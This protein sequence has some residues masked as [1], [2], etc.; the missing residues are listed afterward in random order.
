MKTIIYGAL[1]L[2]TGVIFLLLL[3][4]KVAAQVII[5]EVLPNPD[6]SFAKSEWVELYNMGTNAVDLGNWTL[7]GKVIPAGATIPAGGFLVFTKD[8][9]EFNT[10]FSSSSTAVLQLGF[11]LANAG[12]TLQLQNTSKQTVDTFSYGNSNSYRDISWERSA[13]LTAQPVLHCFGDSL[14]TLNQHW[15]LPDQSACPQIRFSVD[16]TNWTDSIE[17]VGR[18]TIQVKLFNASGLEFQHWTVQGEVLSDEISTIDLYNHVGQEILSVNHF[19]SREVNIKTDQLTLWPNLRINEVSRTQNAGWIEIFNANNF[20]IDLSNWQIDCT[21]QTLLSNISIQPLSYQTVDLPLECLES[22]PLELKLNSSSGFKIDSVSFSN[23][24]TA[25]NWSID[26]AGSWT[27][28]YPPSPGSVNQSATISNLQL[29]ELFPSPGAGETEWVELYNYGSSPIDLAGWSLADLSGAMQL[30]GTIDGYSYLV[31]KPLAISLNNG[32][33]TIE[34]RRDNQ[35]QDYWQYQTIATGTSTARIFASSSYSLDTFLAKQP[36]PGMQNEQPATVALSTIADAKELALESE[37]RLEGLVTA[38]INTF[39]ETE[40]YI[41]DATGGIKV[42]FSNSL[43]L[44]AIT[45]G[46]RL[47]LVGILKQSGGEL[48]IYIDNP[49][50]VTIEQGISVEPKQLDRNMAIDAG[51]LVTVQGK[52]SK[53]YSTSFDLQTNYGDIRVSRQLIKG[54]E[55]TSGAEINV[56][57]ILTTADELYRIL[58]R[59]VSDIRMLKAFTSKTDSVVKPAVSKA[60]ASQQLP[61][62][63]IARTQAAIVGL[64]TST[65]SSEL[66]LP[67]W[68]LAL[69]CFGMSSLGYALWNFRYYLN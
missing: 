22:R 28:N 52:V 31:V 24:Q 44:P 19:R 30:S 27:S 64:P 3:A 65:M 12:S 33:D 37:V 43:T 66:K 58:P 2:V 1:P 10:H 5:S 55:I 50:S 38:D 45:I 8:L 35:V 9:T 40:L 39:V 60:S 42:D 54:M 16:G 63:T 68:Q 11:S 15:H 51:W 14:L 53:V 57:G 4:Q 20:T 47:S 61:V 6:A 67:I 23:D 56:V 69:G 41:Q 62:V 36:T 34:L 26:L 18:K 7:A 21:K 25:W 49:Q 13:T 48:K 59:S 17:A 32:G 46:K 29:S